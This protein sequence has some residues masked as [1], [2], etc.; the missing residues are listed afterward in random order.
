MDSNIVAV[1]SFIHSVKATFY[2]ASRYVSLRHTKRAKIAR[3]SVPR[4]FVEVSTQW[5]QSEFPGATTSLL[6]ARSGDNPVTRSGFAPVACV[7]FSSSGGCPV[8]VPYSIRRTRRVTERRGVWD[9]ILGPPPRLVG[10]HWLLLVCS[11]K[12]M[13][14]RRIPPRLA[15]PPSVPKNRSSRCSAAGSKDD[16]HRQGQ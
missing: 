2:L 15:T 3:P 9:A 1:D 11:W 8:G 5:L 14:N 16:T 7:T 6:I 12:W 13:A 10:D 4:L